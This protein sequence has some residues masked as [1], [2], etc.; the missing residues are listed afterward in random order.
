MTYPQFKNKHLEEAFI[1]PEDWVSYR[2]FDKSKFPQKYILTYQSS[3]LRHFRRE[4][5]GRYEILKIHQGVNI[6]KIKGTS[7]GFL[8]IPGVGAPMAVTVAEELIG[9]GAKEFINI[10]TAG[11]LQHEGVFLCER[12]IR[13]EGTSYHYLPHGTYSYP[14]RQLTNSLARSLTKAGLE[15]ERG[16]TWTIDTPYRETK[17][18]IAQYK[19]KGIATVEME[20]SALF[21][22]AE[23]RKR[24]IASAFVVSDTIGKKWEPKFHHINTKRT[25]NA[26]CDAAI[27]C[28]R[29]AR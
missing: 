19:K 23:Y 8:K 16:T 11:G 28:L 14:T 4:Y 9:L 1:H 6:H 10:G 21:A 17:A 5:A 22:L 29:G 2:K 3:V 18:E 20:A 24:Q 26:L 13:D 15:F 12:A 25:L 27:D 7:I